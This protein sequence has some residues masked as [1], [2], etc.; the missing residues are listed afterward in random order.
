MWLSTENK[1]KQR[2]IERLIDWELR[3]QLQWT[4]LFVATV[5]GLV[6][7]LTGSQLKPFR[8]PFFLIYILLFL[9]SDYGFLRM[10]LSISIMRNYFEDLPNE[11]MKYELIDKAH[12]SWLFDIFSIKRKSKNG[13]THEWHPRRWLIA[14]LIIAGDFILVWAFLSLYKLQFL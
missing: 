13:R 3:K 11:R 2:Q 14:A 4:A 5:L 12:M 10:T 1:E 8:I 9:A 6:S 7:L